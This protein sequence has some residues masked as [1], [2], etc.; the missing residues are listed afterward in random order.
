MVTATIRVGRVP[1][2]VAVNPRTNTIYVTNANSGTVSVI[3]GRT[4]TVTATIRLGGKFPV[5][6]AANPRTDT[7]YVTRAGNIVTRGRV[8]VISG[9][10]NAVMAPSA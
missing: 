6:V 2:G 8:S 5:G 1:A 9:R 10:T 3:S 4:N 7:I